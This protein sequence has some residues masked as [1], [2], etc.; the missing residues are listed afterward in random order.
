MILKG[1]QEKPFVFVKYMNQGSMRESEPL[2]MTFKK[3]Y[4]TGI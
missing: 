4:F 3:V 2:E 1:G